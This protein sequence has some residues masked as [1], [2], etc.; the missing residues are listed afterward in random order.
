MQVNMKELGQYFELKAKYEPKITPP[1]FEWKSCEIT[2]EVADDFDE[3]NFYLEI[4]NP[5]F[6]FCLSLYDAEELYVSLGAAIE[7]L[8][9]IQGAYNS[10]SES[11][12]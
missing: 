1:V 8:K 5:N 6:M 11:I 2:T 9:Q 10:I 3:I 4:F 7:H 12:S